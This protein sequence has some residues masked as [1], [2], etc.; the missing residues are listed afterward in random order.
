MLESKFKDLLEKHHIPYKENDKNIIILCPICL[1]DGKEKIKLY[2]DK[3]SFIFHC[4]RC[5]SKGN[6][7]KLYDTLQEFDK[8]PEYKEFV[9]ELNNLKEEFYINYVSKSVEISSIYDEFQNKESVK[10]LINIISNLNKITLELMPPHKF[11]SKPHLKYLKKRNIEVLY[12][13][14]RFITDFQV[15]DKLIIGS[16]IAFI[17][18]F[19]SK[20]IMRNINDKY[21][22]YRYIVYDV[23]NSNK[24]KI[25]TNSEM[26][27][28]NIPDFITFNLYIPSDILDIYVFEG[29]FDSLSFYNFLIDRKFEKVYSKMFTK[30]HESIYNDFKR[31]VWC[32]SINGK[33]NIGKIL[34]FIFIKYIF[35]DLNISKINL[36]VFFDNDVEQKFI[37]STQRRLLKEIKTFEYHTGI[38]V[39]PTVSKVSSLIK[40][41]SNMTYNDVKDFNE[42]LIKIGWGVKYGWYK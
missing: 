36:N 39:V 6:S 7:K 24:D 25:F 5:E 17:T 41:V 35:D 1:Q 32:I 20:I 30:Y 22:K 18:D 8:F 27:Y 40:F 21:I 12:S 2:I 14:V 31:N 34:E 4:F 28:V 33:H 38:N 16:G 11:T 13:N 9:N 3:E 37:L 10:N 26:Y 29:V 42:F 15:N 19:K 23:L